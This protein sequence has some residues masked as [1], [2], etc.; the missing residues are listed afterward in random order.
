M[1]NVY[2]I[3]TRAH[4]RRV[5]T[6]NL[7]KPSQTK[8]SSVFD[9]PTRNAEEGNRKLTETVQFILAL[10][11]LIG[12][13]KAMGYLTYRLNQ[14]AVLGE[15]LAGVILGPTLLHLLGVGG[16]FLDGEAVTHSLIEISEIG[17][18]LLM[19]MAGM[20]VDLHNLFNVGKPALYA[21]LIGVIVPLVVITPVITLFG[22][23]TERAIFLGILFASM[24]TS[25]TA[26]VMLELGVLQRREG[27][28]LLGAALVDDAVV[29]LLLSV[30]L[31]VNPG[32]VVIGGDVNSSI[33]LVL[34]K[35]VGFLVIG[36]LASWFLLPRLINWVNNLPISQG[37]LM[38]ALVAILLLSASAEIFGG[39]AAITG[40][41]IAGV[42]I[43]Q[44]RRSVVERIERGLH[45]IGYAFVVPLFFVSIG[46]QANLR[47]L[48]ADLLPFAL[49]ILALAIGTKVLGAGGGTR[50]AGFDNTSALRVGLGMISRGEVGLIIASIGVGYQILTPE[51]FTVVVFV[52]LVT[53]IITPPLV[54]WSFTERAKTAQPIE[55][56][57]EEAA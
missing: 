12:F 34:V 16:F 41:F 40:A 49:V 22:Y 3:D 29:I 32:G 27:L 5:F 42:C 53:T 37:A 13:A 28:T 26:Q 24:S 55:P 43:R 48:T 19:A 54:R 6:V 47:L 46:L 4:L 56:F 10:G 11:L 36:S 2:Y 23:S 50:L 52:V 33:P 35:I 44:A 30:F 31:A 57:A 39:I 45:S 7:T 20:E 25:I 17:V 14:P 9:I 1:F 8:I 38:V 18:L 51:V 21:G 15:L